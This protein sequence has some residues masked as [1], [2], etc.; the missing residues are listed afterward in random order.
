MQ[1]SDGSSPAAS[2]SALAKLHP[3]A[4]TTKP[5]A[6]LETPKCSATTGLSSVIRRESRISAARHSVG[7]SSAWTAKPR[8]S[9]PA[10]A[11][12]SG[13][14]KEE[15]FSGTLGKGPKPVS[16]MTG[17]CAAMLNAQ[18]GIWGCN[19]DHEKSIA[20]KGSPLGRSRALARDLWRLLSGRVQTQHRQDLVCRARW[21]EAAVAD[22]SFDRRQPRCDLRIGFQ[23]SQEPLL[24]HL[25]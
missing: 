16:R 25:A 9:R 15:A 13:T 20:V 14:S 21:H 22:V 6:L 11:S 3:R 19:G 24:Q 23:G 12:T 5:I 8:K 1:R 17:R 7:I 18:F 2:D 4:S 10:F